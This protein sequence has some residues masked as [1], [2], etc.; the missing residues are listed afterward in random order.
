MYSQKVLCSLAIRRTD[1]L[2]SYVTVEFISGKWL[3]AAEFDVCARVRFEIATL[4][5]ETGRVT[6]QLFSTEVRVLGFCEWLSG[7]PRR[8][9]EYFDAISLRV[10][11]VDRPRVSVR[12][13]HDL[14]NIVAHREVV[15]KLL[16]LF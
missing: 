13:R 6:L 15:V 1:R 16:D 12:Y 10:V 2:A 3:H 9:T 11:E 7:I 5:D 8:I 14:T 4:F